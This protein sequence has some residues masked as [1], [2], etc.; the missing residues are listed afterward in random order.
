MK[1][2]LLLSFTI[3]IANASYSGSKV[4]EVWNILEENPY[5]MLPQTKVNMKRLTKW[6]KSKL[7]QSARRTLDNRNDILPYFEKLV[8][9]NG[10]CLL[11]EWTITQETAYS[12]YFKKDSKGLIIARASSAL[13]HT[14]SG[15]N[16]S[17]G[18]AGKIYPTAD[19]YHEENLVP[20]NFF[21]IDD[22]AGTKVSQFSKAALTNEPDISLNFGSIFLLRMAAFVAKIFKKADENPNIRQLWQ[23]SSLGESGNDYIKTPMW[24]RL[25]AN[26]NS[27]GLWSYDFRDEFASYIE[28]N[29]HMTFDIEVAGKLENGHNQKQVF[30]KIGKIEFFKN[31]SS[32]NCDH[33]LHFNHPQW[34]SD[35]K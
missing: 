4:E 21:T 19:F 13:S 2:F 33:R 30:K 15:K 24:M 25:R 8:H 7:A 27:K 34:R 3:N 16:R 1:F 14:E 20:A 17:F 29:N 26:K 31:V 28:A 23:I 18:L 6:G 35:I 22:L 9:A 32:K 5:Q 12:G 11:G 10:T